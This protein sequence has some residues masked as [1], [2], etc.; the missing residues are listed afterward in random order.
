MFPKEGDFVAL[1][2]MIKD[3][4]PVT[5]IVNHFKSS[6]LPEK[7]SIKERNKA[8]FDKNVLFTQVGEAQSQKFKKLFNGLDEEDQESI[9]KWLDAFVMLTEKC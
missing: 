9:W 2:I 7:K 1:R 5:Q 3:Q 6:L 8:F 4:I